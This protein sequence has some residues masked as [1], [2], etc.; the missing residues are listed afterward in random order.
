MTT[1]TIRTPLD[2]RGIASILVVVALALVAAAFVAAAL[3][4]THQP[5][6]PAGLPGA[7]A[8]APVAGV[9]TGLH[10]GALATAH[11]DGGRVERAD[12]G[13]ASAPVAAGNRSWVRES[14][15]RAES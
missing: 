6:S 5:A 12:D 15:G 8:A 1:T 10:D 13:S 2:R 4:R 7:A 14:G 3:V 9:V 11:H